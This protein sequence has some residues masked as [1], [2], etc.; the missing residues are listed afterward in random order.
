MEGK[1]RKKI[2]WNDEGVSEILSDVLILAMTT[3]LFAAVFAMVWNLP[4]PDEDLYAN[5]ESSLDMN[6]VGGVI[7]ITHLGGET[8]IGF[9]TAIYL[10]KNIDEEIRILSTK[11]SDAD[12]PEYGIE[13]DENWDTGEKWKYHHKGISE[14]DDVSILIVDTKSN[15]MVL[16]SNLQGKGFNSPPMI[17]E[18]WYE[19][20]PAVN[21][22]QVT[23]YAKIVDYNGCDDVRSVSFDASSLNPR[24]GIMEMENSDGDC[25][26]EAEVLINTNPGEFQL[27]V[28]AFD[29]ENA[30][31]SARLRM[32]V[33]EAGNPIIEFVAIQPNSVE[34]GDEFIIRAVVV[35][36]NG[37]LNLSGVS[38]YPEQKFYDDGGSIDTSLELTDEIPF[39][40]IFETQGTAP[41]SEG[42]FQLTL[43]AKDNDEHT[44]TKQLDLSVIRD[45]TG[46]GNGSFND[47]I[48]AYLGPES[49]DFKKFYYTTDDPPINTTEY[50]LAVYIQ[51]DHIGTD[52]YLHINVINHYDHDVYI[53]GNSKLRLLQI[54]GAA[55]NKDLDIVQNGTNFGDPVGTTPDGSWYMIPKA[56]DGDYF[57]G[58]EPVSLVFGPFDLQS[59]KAGDLFGS[60]L[61]LTGS[62]VSESTDAEDRLGQTLPFQGILI[63]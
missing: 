2:I 62:Y 5:F 23:V 52:C 20:N 4:P 17:M 34:V 63:S 59:A 33:E 14:D 19:P 7:N 57:H 46:Q 6:G 61:V 32:K 45:D 27:T 47:S 43:E 48:W 41:I 39:G 21:D 28:V 44:S 25:I 1:V 36:L 9:N 15:R 42:G 53:D 13:G 54:G 40:G 37:D 29:S 60:I 18:R 16:N 12:N 49:L 55:S 56:D 51:E 8:L 30:S 22:S 11:G 38:V 3:V 24:V 58:G 35:D 31:D 26:Y 50:H 10:Y